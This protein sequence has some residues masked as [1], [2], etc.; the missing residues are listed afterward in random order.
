MGPP[1]NPMII[2]RPYSERLGEQLLAMAEVYVTSS[3]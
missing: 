1:S 3:A 2:D